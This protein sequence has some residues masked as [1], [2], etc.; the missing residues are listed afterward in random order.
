MDLTQVRANQSRSGRT[1]YSDGGLTTR[2]TVQNQVHGYAVPEVGSKA[3]GIDALRKAFDSFYS[4]AQKG[5]DAI[6]SAI[7]HRM[8]FE[9]RQNLAD[10]ERQ[11]SKEKSKAE[12]D[13]MSGKEPDQTLLNDTD[14]IDVYKGLKGNRDSVPLYEDWKSK[15]RDTLSVDGPDNILAV[16]EDYIQ[17]EWGS[18]TGDEVYDN[19]ILSGF[20]KQAEKDI[21]DFNGNRQ[22]VFTLKRVDEALSN[23]GVQFRNGEFKPSNMRDAVDAIRVMAPELYEEAPKMVMNRLFMETHG[24]PELAN[25]VINYLNDPQSGVNGRSAVQT[26]DAAMEAEQRYIQ[27][28]QNGVTWESNKAWNGLT[29]RLMKVGESQDPAGELHS[30]MSAAF[31]NRRRYG[32]QNQFESITSKA[33][34]ALDKMSEDKADLNYFATYADDVASNEPDSVPDVDRLKRG[35]IKWLN[36]IGGYEQNPEQVAAVVDKVG[37]INDDIKVKASQG[38]TNLT[39]PTAF[40]RSFQFY[41]TIAKGRRGEAGALQMMSESSRSI[42][43]R[44]MLMYDQGNTDLASISQTIQNS[45]QDYDIVKKMSFNEITGKNDGDKVVSRMIQDSLKDKVREFWRSDPSEAFSPQTMSKLTELVKHEVASG[46]KAGLSDWQSAVTRAMKIAEGQ[47]SV[48]PASDGKVELQVGMIPEDARFSREKL[49]PGYAEPQDDV[50]VYRSDITDVVSKFPDFSVMGADA[51]DADDFNAVWDAR[52]KTGDE[53]YGAFSVNH[54]GRPVILS[55]E[56]KDTIKDVDAVS[57]DRVFFVKQMTQM[58]DKQVPYY[59]VYYKPGPVGHKF[60]TAAEKATD[61]KQPT[62]TGGVIDP[63]GDLPLIQE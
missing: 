29:E 54:L 9:H 26:W 45:Q 41:R 43:D 3:A 58:G 53:S 46:G 17:K 12:A 5:L 51:T 15:V 33:I 24:K 30:I 14:Y 56:E 19:A 31:D 10:V 63:M 59:L 38:L 1:S 60:Q 37:V 4:P 23:I 27:D 36:S 49:Y 2:P 16:T 62:P 48:T 35:Q 11:N 47:I 13:F 25:Q 52:I 34:T 50:K 21:S 39:D 61:Y 18:G 42:F 8:E 44:A 7:D 55:E 20:W 40:S 22:K 32:N 6:Q 57:K 28:Y